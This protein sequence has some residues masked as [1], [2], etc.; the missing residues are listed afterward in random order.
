[1]IKIMRYKLVG[2]TTNE[3]EDVTFGTCEMRMST[4]TMTEQFFISKM[5]LEKFTKSKNMHETGE[6]FMKSMLITS[7]SSLHD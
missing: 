7:P 5:K 6:I 2:Y 1:M 3:K 4:G